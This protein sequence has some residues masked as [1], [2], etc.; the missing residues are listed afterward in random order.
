M[1]IG[2]RS[3]RYLAEMYAESIEVERARQRETAVAART[4]R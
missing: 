3:R 1:V 4:L 2:T